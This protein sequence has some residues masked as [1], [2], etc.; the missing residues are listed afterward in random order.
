MFRNE[1]NTQKK[2]HC[3]L[4]K[5]SITHCV[6]LYLNTL[7]Y[8]WCAYV[9]FCIRRLRNRVRNSN[10]RQLIR[11]GESVKLWRLSSSSRIERGKREREKKE[12]NTSQSSK[13]LCC[14]I[15][16]NWF[17]FSFDLIFGLK[18]IGEYSNYFWSAWY[19]A[20]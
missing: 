18:W 16:L 20:C 13:F 11:I 1:T 6:L 3:A 15:E 9:Q 10:L 2:V 12:R 4:W 7:L 5:E 8:W 14:R 17:S 19:K